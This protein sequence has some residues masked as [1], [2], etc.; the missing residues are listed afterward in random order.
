M[1]RGLR[2]TGANWPT[3]SARLRTS[4]AYL[5]AYYYTITHRICVKVVRESLCETGP[6]LPAGSPHFV[7]T[8]VDTD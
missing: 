7:D 1:H 4:S 6:A 8:K 3:I 5:A 2:T